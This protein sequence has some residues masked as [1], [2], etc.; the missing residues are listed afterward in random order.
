MQQFVD[1]SIFFPETGTF[2]KI[3]Q[4][5]ASKETVY[6]FDDTTLEVAKMPEYDYYGRQSVSEEHVQSPMVEVS[7]YTL[8]KIDEK[9]YTLKTY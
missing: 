9:V 2:V 8:V 3:V 6:Y 5:S 1:S 4:V 7:I